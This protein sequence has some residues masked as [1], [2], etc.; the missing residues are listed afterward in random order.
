MTEIENEPVEVFC[1]YVRHVGMHWASIEEAEAKMAAHQISKVTLLEKLRTFF[2]DYL[3]LFSEL[4]LPTMYISRIRNDIGHVL[5]W[6]SAMFINSRKS[7]MNTPFVT[8]YLQQKRELS[9]EMKHE[10]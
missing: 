10:D 5:F 6:A 7:N 1:R 8:K 3:K 9:H 4:T 2:T